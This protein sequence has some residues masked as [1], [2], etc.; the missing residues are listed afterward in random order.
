M[1][2]FEV[3]QI[4]LKGQRGSPPFKVG[5]INLY[6]TVP[7][8]QK[9]EKNVSVLSS[10]QVGFNVGHQNS[11][12]EVSGSNIVP[13]TLYLVVVGLVVAIVCTNKIDTVYLLPGS[14]LL[15]TMT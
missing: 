8:F 15:I 1:P 9:W 13:M 2:T 7:K 11:H 6:H 10:K 5:L 14:T 4:T 12:G 3:P